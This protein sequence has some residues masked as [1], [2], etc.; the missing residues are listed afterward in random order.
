MDISVGIIV[1]NEENN[2]GNLLNSISRQKTKNV[3]INEIIVVSSGST[4]RTNKIVRG[5]SKKNNK[6]KLIIQKKRKGK[7]SAINEF[8]KKAK[9]EILVLESGDTLPEKNAIGSLSRP[10]TN[11]KIGIVASHP[12]PLNNKK[13]FL[14]SAIRLQWLLHHK[15]SLKSPKFGELIA[16]RKVFDKIENTAADEEYI[17]ML[18]KNNRLLGAYA[19]DAMVHNTGPKTIASLIK[20]RRRIY[21]GHLELKKKYGYKAATM[22][23]FLVFSVILKEL[24]IKNILPVAFGIF[25]EVYSRLLGLYDYY[26]DKKHYIWNVAK[27]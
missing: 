11:K 20:Q 12:V 17:A 10:L 27:K 9:S 16:F 8:L 24:R 1:Y 4:D 15:I 26:T 19:P 3:K 7:A 22:R 2:I 6:I 14:N 13:S 5:F 25:I 18:I 23:N 21:W